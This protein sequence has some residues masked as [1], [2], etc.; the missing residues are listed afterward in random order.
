M[1]LII[2]YSRG[3]FMN[4]LKLSKWLKI[5][6]IGSGICGTV[7]YF[8]VFP[9]WGK[10]IIDSNPE[11]SSSYW[12]WLLFLWI[13]SIPCYAVLVFSWKIAEEVGKDN[14]FCLKNANSLN[15]I[16]IFAA[17]DSAFFFTGNIILLVM[18][19]NHPGIVLLAFFVVFGG[20]VVTV[21]AA[22]LSHLVYKAAQIREE[23]ELTI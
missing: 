7:I 9:F 19:R 12:I 20:V 2:N 3:T 6:I 15:S 21:T 22:A 11:F 14:S 16:S 4:Q 18:N 13:T 8:Y 17:S 5:I 1:V 23:N 10:A